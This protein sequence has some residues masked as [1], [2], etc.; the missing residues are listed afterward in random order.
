MIYNLSRDYSRLYDLLCEGEE[1]VCFVAYKVKLTRTTILR[2]D[3]CRAKRL[4]EFHIDIN[5]RGRGYGGIFPVDNESDSELKL[6]R[7]ECTR[8]N[9]EWIDPEP[10]ES[11][12]PK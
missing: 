2:R 11:E 3:V 10:K 7:R 6:L 9:L 8:L 4:G 12:E 5:V 1:V